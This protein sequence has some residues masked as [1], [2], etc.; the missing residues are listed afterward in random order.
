MN[1]ELEH[2]QR[3]PLDADSTGCQWLGAEQQGPLYYSVCTHTSLAGSSYCEEHHG[4]V[5]QRG[6]SL[7]RRKKDHRRAAAVWDIESAFN[8]AVEELESEGI[9]FA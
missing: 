8:E 9:D 4:R 6:T 2:T 3:T 1:N 7:G 5:Y